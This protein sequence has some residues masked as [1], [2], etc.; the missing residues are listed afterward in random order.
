MNRDVCYTLV[1]SGKACIVDFPVCDEIS[2]A[3]RQLVDKLL[4]SKNSTL[5]AAVNDFLPSD[6]THPMRRIFFVWAEF[7]RAK[8]QLFA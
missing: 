8:D 2:G 6:F 5:Q 7:E 1:L 3:K 4:K